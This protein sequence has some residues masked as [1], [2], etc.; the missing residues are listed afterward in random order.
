VGTRRVLWVGL[1]SVLTAV[2][3]ATAGEHIISF[4]GVA[5]R[6]FVGLYDTPQMAHLTLPDDTKTPVP[7][8]G[9]RPADADLLL[10]TEAPPPVSAGRQTQPL[11]FAPGQGVTNPS[12]VKE[13]FLVEAFWAIQTGTPAGYFKRAHFHPADL[14]SG[15]EAQHF[16]NPKELHGIY[17]RSLDGKPFGVKSLRYRV[18]RNRELPHRPHS[19]EGFSN[20]SVQV[21]LARTFDPRWSIRGQFVG[22]AVGLPAGSDSTLPWW[23]L[24]VT[25]FGAVEQIYIASS[26]SVDFDDIVLTR[27]RPYEEPSVKEGEK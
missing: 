23:T 7:A 21:L 17:I 14:S 10:G 22:S 15:F 24:S 20:Y 16:G 26:A 13:G 19:I 25:G 27:L 11:A 8:P 2:G 18:T 5:V 3:P 4:N 9:K 12:F 1:C 6:G